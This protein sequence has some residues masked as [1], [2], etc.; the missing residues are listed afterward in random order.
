MNSMT[1]S[2]KKII[3]ETTA[4]AK[5]TAIAAHTALFAASAT[6][7]FWAQADAAVAQALKVQQKEAEDVAPSSAAADSEGTVDPSTGAG[8]KSSNDDESYIPYEAD[9]VCEEAILSGAIPLSTSKAT[10]SG[11]PSKMM[12][13]LSQKFGESNPIPKQ[14][15]VTETVKK[16]NGKTVLNKLNTISFLAKELRKDCREEGKK[17]N[18]PFGIVNPLQFGIER[19]DAILC[20]HLEHSF[21]CHV[22]RKIL[23]SLKDVTLAKQKFL[24]DVLNHPSLHYW[25]TPNVNFLLAHISLAVGTKT[26]HAYTRKLIQSSFDYIFFGGYAIYLDL[27]DFTSDGAGHEML[28]NMFSYLINGMVSAE[29]L[30]I[31]QNDQSILES[32]DVALIQSLFQQ[33]IHWLNKCIQ[34]L[35]PQQHSEAPPAFYSYSY[36]KRRKDEWEKLS[37]DEKDK[38]RKEAK[39]NRLFKSVKQLQDLIEIDVSSAVR[40]LAHTATIKNPAEKIAKAVVIFAQKKIDLQ[41]AVKIFST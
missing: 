17:N 35:Q 14:H 8:G 6:T 27:S 39:D 13:Q 25:T 26:P 29:K 12:S 15:T 41:A 38:K 31:S 10:I 20:S 16:K 4:A 32:E 28:C 19:S 21:P 34:C 7:Q 1:F 30:L 33:R 23:C 11:S 3:H 9:V 36:A 40:A 24:S 18:L 5:A 2:Y 37:F 22:A